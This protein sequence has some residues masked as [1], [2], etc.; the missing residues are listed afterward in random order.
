VKKVIKPDESMMEEVGNRKGEAS[1]VRGEASIEGESVIHV[2]S[3]DNFTAFST[4]TVS[5]WGGDFLKAKGGHAGIERATNRIDMTRKV[6]IDN[7]PINQNLVQYWHIRN[8][9]RGT[10]RK[11][12][13]AI[14][15]S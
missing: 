10:S 13:I 14:L 8:S 5:Y 7:I 1:A 2:V 12:A 6:I 11:G 4:S 15:Y 9:A 3:Y